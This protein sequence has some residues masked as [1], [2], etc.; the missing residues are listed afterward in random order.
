[1]EIDF[2]NGDETKFN[3]DYNY[4]EK[5]PIPL[6]YDKYDQDYRILHVPQGRFKWEFAILGFVERLKVQTTKKHFFC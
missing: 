2:R 5:L 4:F 1:M 6:K 3:H